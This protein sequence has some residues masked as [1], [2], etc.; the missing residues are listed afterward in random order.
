[1]PVNFFFYEA[2]TWLALP[3]FILI[4]VGLSWVV[5]LALRPWV[6][7]AA[8]AN[9]EWDRVLGYAMSSYGIFYGILLAL[10]AVS[11]YENFQRV[12]AVVLDEVSSLGALYR[13]VSSY[14]GPIAGQLQEELRLYTVGVIE[15]DWPSMQ[16]NIIPTVGSDRIDSLQ[17]TLFAFEPT[18]P[19]NTVVHSQAMG[20]FFDFLE[21]RRA[22]LEET[23]LALPGL[24]WAVLAVGAVL[25]AV[26]ISSSPATCVCTSSCRVSSRCSW[27]C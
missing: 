2:P 6:K 10:I 21:D 8:A 7:R 3:T 20:L 25:N 14:P 18:T 19:G 4:F 12:D 17:A 16:Q 26:M 5:L 13:A 1:V 22:R 11:V 15:V 24:L 9:P 23:K 27:R